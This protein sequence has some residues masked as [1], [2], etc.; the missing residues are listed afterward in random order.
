MAFA[1]QFKTPPKSQ[2][3]SNLSQH[4][5]VVKAK[6]KIAQDDTNTNKS[7]KKTGNIFKYILHLL[8]YSKI[9]PNM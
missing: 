5:G 9:I 4:S 8:L 1:N 6:D 3:K 7:R 2:V